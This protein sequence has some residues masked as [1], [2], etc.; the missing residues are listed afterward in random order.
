MS[1]W[2][3]RDLGRAAVLRAVVVGGPVSRTALASRLG[4]S[5]AT[6]TLLTREL[7]AEGLLETAGKEAGS[8]R[9]RPAE[10]LQVVPGAGVALGVKV[11]ASR[12]TGVLVDLRGETLSTFESPFDAAVAEPV[13]ALAELLRPHVEA[14]GGRLI[15]VGLGVPGVVD[16]GSGDV[17]AATLRWADVPVGAGL[18]ELLQLP[19]VVDND[20]HTLAIAEHLYGRAQ[21]AQDDLI[22]TVG[23]G[24]GLA[25]TVA[26]RLHRGARGGAGEFGHT[27]AVENGPPCGCGRDGC[28]EAIASETGML[29]RAVA[30][31]L[32]PPD[33][34]IE[35]LRGLAAGDAAARAIFEEAGR[36]LG[37]SVADLVNVLAPS[38]VLVAGE[39]TAA[40]GL[41]EAAF[42]SGFEAQVLDTHREVEIAVD[43][44]WDDRAWAR[45]ASALLLGSVYAPEHASGVGQGL[46][47]RDRLTA[48]NGGGGDG[49]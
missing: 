31:G 11:A 23:R 26:G 48:M 38:L 29:R 35:Q 44:R 14:A 42:R 22:V 27:R 25:I 12:V 8:S 28:L 43:D 39:G 13:R 32:L 36:V 21:D 19:V 37:R 16:T 10:L 2:S 24:I 45:G 6:V 5:P 47:A 34:T 18:A 30:S 20:V 7:L 9:G 40:W 41:L 15:G 3:E 49:R 46:E 1:G 4:V 17:T 33:G